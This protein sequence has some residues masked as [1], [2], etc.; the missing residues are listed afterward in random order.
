MCLM[1]Y[2]ATEDDVPLRR[3]AE[4]SVEAV[5]PSC[6]AVRQWFSLPVVRFIAVPT[7]C[8]CGFPH[9]LAEEPLEYYDGMFDGDDRESVLKSVD[10][11]LALVR[12]HV[13]ATAHVELYP[14]WSGGEGER[15][16]GRID[17]RVAA[18][19]RDRFFVIEQFLYR[20]T[21]GFQIEA[22]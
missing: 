18:L 9:V 5:E 20:V 14:I 2:I 19:D 16:K 17:L 15:P 6:E 1:L 4:L 13:T 22:S 8:S 21:P 3:S 7:S 10:A 12:E 11:L